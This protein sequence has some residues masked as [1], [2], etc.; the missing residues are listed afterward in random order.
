MSVEQ[1]FDLRNAENI[2]A[3]RKIS[4]CALKYLKNVRSIYIDGS[5]TGTFFA[6]SLPL[7]SSF[8]VFT[9]SLRM[10]SVLQKKPHITI[11]MIGGIYRREMSTFDSSTSLSQ[12][13]N[14]YIDMSVISCTG[15][16]EKGTVNNS[17]AILSEH[18]CMIEN[19]DQTLLLADASKCG[20][21]ALI[22][23]ESWKN[24]NTFITDRPF[25]ENVMAAIRHQNVDVVW[26]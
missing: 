11:F 7:D 24:I 13:K 9:N 25:D 5:T 17:I 14:V 18:R 2:E 1:P 23:A 3:K 20:R 22:P 8:T 16:N 19:S 10:V 15:F 21:R 12:L 6:D 26:D 4:Q